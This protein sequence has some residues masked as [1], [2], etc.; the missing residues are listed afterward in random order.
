[1]PFPT[2]RL[3]GI[4]GSDF[5]QVDATSVAR[6]IGQTEEFDLEFK[7]QM[8]GGG[9]SD[10]AEVAKDVAAFANYQGGLIMIGVTD[11][12][13]VAISVD[14]WDVTETDELRIREIVTERVVPYIDIAIQRVASQDARKG[15]LLIAVPG[16]NDAPH[17]VRVGD[18]LRYPVRDGKR[19][20]FMA[21]AE[22]A[23]SY[24][25]RF[26][27]LEER[28]RRVVEV[29]SGGVR[30]LLVDAEPQRP[31][32]T[33]TLVPLRPV[34][35]NLDASVRNTIEGQF[36]DAL[37]ESCPNTPFR[38]RAL[39]QQRVGVREVQ[40]T[41]SNTFGGAP[42]ASFAVLHS[43]GSAFVA[44]AFWA[45]SNDFG[46]G[47]DV[48]QIS[49]DSMT[50]YVLGLMDLAC[51]H[52][53]ASGAGGDA[54]LAVRI[55]RPEDGREIVLVRDGNFIPP[56]SGWPRMDPSFA[57]SRFTVPPRQIVDS[58]SE[59]VAASFQVLADLEAAFGEPEPLFVRRDGTMT[60][61]FGSIPVLA[62]WAALRGIELR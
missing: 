45:G 41:D 40:I 57:E 62:E 5:E 15:F 61:Q 49:R 56:A 10:R 52:A 36:R 4:F 8:Y 34:N 25:R 55:A 2:R 38:G 16:S 35:L 28:S 29:Q 32:L 33:A 42:R 50:V 24:R 20:R 26:T 11:S 27:A 12:D 37:N 30:H 14:P 9:D 3:V 53:V 18:K 17:A 19:T 54:V 44:A 21:E 48:V 43:D 31:W 59:L 1:M 46:D 47:T 13:G 7:V 58:G 23:T 22:V 51:Q 60:P 39:L 6:L